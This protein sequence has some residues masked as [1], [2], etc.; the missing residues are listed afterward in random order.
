MSFWKDLRQRRIIQILITYLAGGWVALA[1]MDQIISRGL[2]PEVSYRIALVLYLTGAVVSLVIG[3]YH[4]EKGHQ[5]ATPL[6]MV[7]LSLI[8]LGGLGT[9]VFV[10]Q[11]H[12]QPGLAE[13]SPLNLH[14][15]GVLYLENDGGDAELTAVADGLTEDLIAQLERVPSL[16]VISERGVRQYRDS[17]V[18]PDS[19]AR[20]L[21][22]G[23]LITGSVR[24]VGED[25]RVSVNLVDGAS[26]TRVRDASFAWRDDYLVDARGELARN[27]SLL[28]REWLGEEVEVRRRRRSTE[29]TEA[30][31]TVQRAEREVA[32]AELRL[33][34]DDLEGAIAA[35]DHADSL[36]SLAEAMDTTWAEPP[37]LRGE[38]AYER[39]RMS[40]SVDD[41]AGWARTGIRH[42]ER[43][44][45][46]QPESAGAL[47]TRGR[48]RYRL[49]ALQAVPNQEEARAL[50]MA[51]R[52]DL[53]TAVRRDPAL[54]EANSILSHLY[55][56]FN[57][58]V[59]AVLAAQRAYEE[60]AYLRAADQLLWR[61][62]SGNYALGNYSQARNWCEEGRE[63]FPDYFRFTECQLWLMT[64][65]ESDPDVE[66]A[67]RLLAE[68]EEMLPPEQREFQTHRA[69]MVVGAVIGRAGLTDSARA[70]LGRA[71]P[72][73]STDP[74]RELVGFEAAMRVIIGDEEEAVSLIRRYETAN[75]GHFQEG[76]DHW[77][78]TPLEDD[79]EF[80]R[81]TGAEH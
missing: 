56:Q 38:V 80:R 59:S 53:E 33:D 40:R 58:K 29:S 70:V 19:I 24:S 68:L 16:D 17:D 2:L 74:H 39:L 18:S 73:P 34:Q 7:L 66:K 4:G 55:F 64:M 77:W 1:G 20:A 79:P 11:V 52:E 62:H 30:W 37:I 50:L 57:E 78:W 76:T 36:L 27:V 15:V 46:R 31:L 44:L 60:D 61:L 35:L 45:E 14:S 32:S 71:R 5:E 63:R 10:Y 25:I 81:L 12:S 72:A 6:E 13:L 43:A 3:W 69:R 23:T 67:W 54:A 22:A 8:A 21:E 75:P 41:A 65:P 51:A 26:G 9:S 48:L 28:L 47:A 42:A 49:W